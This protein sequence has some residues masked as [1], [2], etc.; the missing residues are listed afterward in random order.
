MSTLIKCQELGEKKKFKCFWQG[1]CKSMIS[2]VKLHSGGFHKT[3]A[4]ATQLVL[5]Q[6]GLTHDY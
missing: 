2:A 3:A 4:L 1:A 6:R 5:S